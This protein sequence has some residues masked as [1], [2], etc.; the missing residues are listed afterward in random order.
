MIIHMFFLFRTAFSWLRADGKSEGFPLTH[1]K[2]NRLI[3]DLLK[4]IF[5]NTV[6]AV[7]AVA[8]P[9]TLDRLLVR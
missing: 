8:E 6:V 7:E 5:L 9:D 4:V 3:S 1:Q 2:M